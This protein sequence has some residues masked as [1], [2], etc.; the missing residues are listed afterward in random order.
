MN[1]PSVLLMS[2]A[3]LVLGS[4]AAAQPAADDARL[5]RLKTEAIETVDSSRKLTQEI[6]DSLFSFSEL[7]FQEFE[8]QRYLTTC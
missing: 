8:T 1:R 4:A 2:C 3:S 7:A 5:A 6:V